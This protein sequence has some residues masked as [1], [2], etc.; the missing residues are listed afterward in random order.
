MLRRRLRHLWD[1]R[2]WRGVWAALTSDSFVSFALWRDRDGELVYEAIVAILSGDEERLEVI[3]FVE[4]Q[5]SD[6]IRQ[7]LFD[8]MPD[9]NAGPLKPPEPSEEELRRF[10]DPRRSKAA[11]DL[12]RADASVSVTISDLGDGD[13]IGTMSAVIDTEPNLEQLMD[14]MRRAAVALEG[15]DIERVPPR[16]EWRGPWDDGEESE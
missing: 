1:R 9:W 2:R 11:F 6:A 8:D 13:L 14:A 10:D 5:L 3:E 12:Y 15:A 7:G 4:T 16:I